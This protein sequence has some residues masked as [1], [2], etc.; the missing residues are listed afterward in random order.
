MGISSSS[1]NIGRYC[2]RVFVLLFYVK[3]CIVVDWK[4]ARLVDVQCTTCRLCWQI[5]FARVQSELQT[6]L[7]SEHALKEA[8]EDRITELESKLSQQQRTNDLERRQLDTRLVDMHAQ[9][10]TLKHNLEESELKRK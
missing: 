9:I 7:V 3:I 8:F 6:E 10:T 5:E 4:V 1:M 2:L